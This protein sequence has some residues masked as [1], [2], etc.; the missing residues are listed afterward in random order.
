MESLSQVIPFMLPPSS[1]P[2]RSSQHATLR[3]IS[4]LVHP[5]L[6]FNYHAKYSSPCTCPLLLH[7]FSEF[8][9]FCAY[10]RLLEDSYL[11][12]ACSYSILQSDVFLK[13]LFVF[14]YKSLMLLTKRFFHVYQQKQLP[15]SCIYPNYFKL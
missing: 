7:C 8:Y 3:S 15:L 2:C 6:L 9:W 11:K 5:P 14:C 10:P 12:T 4:V 1:T 13:M